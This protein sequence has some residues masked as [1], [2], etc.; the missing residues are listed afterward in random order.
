M[1]IGC[2]ANIGIVDK[3]IHVI[4]IFELLMLPGSGGSGTTAHGSGGETAVRLPR[5]IG[6]AL[7]RCVPLALTQ[8]FNDAP[9]LVYHRRVLV[10]H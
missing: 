8:L 6:G 9:Q 5:R 3:R 10:H 7:T 4:L 2:I 1:Q